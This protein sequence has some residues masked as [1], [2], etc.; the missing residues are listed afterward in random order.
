MKTSLCV[1][2]LIV[3]LSPLPARAQELPPPLR[4][5]HS[6]ADRAYLSMAFSPDGGALAAGATGVIRILSMEHERCAATTLLKHPAAVDQL[7]FADDEV[8]ISGGDTG[9]I[10]A[11][12]RRSLSPVRFGIEDMDFG[13]LGIRAG[14]QKELDPCSASLAWAHPQRGLQ[15]IGIA[16]MRTSSPSL[17]R[18]Q[19]GSWGRFA[20]GR[21][22]A[23]AW[24]ESTLLA[25]DDHGFLHRLVEVKKNFKS[26]DEATVVIGKHA[27]PQETGGVF[28]PHRGAIT[29]IIPMANGERLLTAGLDG[30]VRLWEMEKIRFSV[31][32]RNPP[33]ADA[34]W[35]I[36]G[37]AADLSPDGALV[38]AA[39]ADGLGVYQVLTG[40]ALSWNSTSVLGGRVIRLHFAPSGTMLAAIVCRCRE[41][42]DP[43]GRAAA[44]PRRLADHGGRLVILK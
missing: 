26:L 5:I 18:L 13:T 34:G 42:L 33:S 28:Q 23:H 16:G 17:R 19:I 27:R 1:I 36:E 6:S 22:T 10:R 11:W 4:E 43:R 37:W 20:L 8:L 21:V 24:T 35:E 38:A 25:G 31:D 2:A 7:A 44:P 30:K 12:D 9:P 41:C 29:A 15:M 14:L 3:L 40:V 39:G 32:R